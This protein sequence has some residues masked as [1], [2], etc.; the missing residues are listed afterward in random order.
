[1]G[2]ALTLNPKPSNF[3]S[4]R[5]GPAA[6]WLQFCSQT[7]LSIGEE[8]RANIRALIIRIGFWA[9]YTILLIRNPQYTYLCSALFV[10]SLSSL[11]RNIVVA[12]VRKG[13]CGSAWTFQASED[14]THCIE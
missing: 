1:M 14:T 11:L 7:T 9:H 6:L 12:V 13:C 10:C 8:R 4:Q 2:L 3:R 5:L